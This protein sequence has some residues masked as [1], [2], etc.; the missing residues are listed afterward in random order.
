MSRPIRILDVAI[1]FGSLI[2]VL[3]DQPDGRARRL[4]FENTGEN[5][6]LVRF[7][8]LRRKLRLTWTSAVEIDL[9][10]GFFQIHPRWRAIDNA[11]Q[12]QSMA[13]SKRGDAERTADGVS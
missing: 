9:D 11:A 2:L 12:R 10:V 4:A 1:V 13:L 7:L 3:D 6:D 5:L 8:A